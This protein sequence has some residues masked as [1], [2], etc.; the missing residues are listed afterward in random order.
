MQ[1]GSTKIAGAACY[2]TLIDRSARLFTGRSVIT[3]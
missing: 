3:V 2:L 1:V